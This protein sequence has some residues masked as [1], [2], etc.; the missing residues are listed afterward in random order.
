MV[1]N[2]AKMFKIEI[3]I[4]QILLLTTAIA[5]WIHLRLPSCGPQVQVPLHNIYAFSIKT[6]FRCETNVNKQ[7]EA[8]KANINITF[9]N[10]KFP[11]IALIGLLMFGLD[12]ACLLCRR[13][14]TYI[15]K[16]V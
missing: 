13:V 11:G 4:E 2:K 14:P 7:K 15:M 3:K 1:I 16:P 10:I 5:Q 9:I 8:V 6:E 12:R